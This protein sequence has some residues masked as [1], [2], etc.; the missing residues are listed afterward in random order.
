[1][2]V[3]YTLPNFLESD[4]FVD[5]VFS[6]FENQTLER[7]INL[8]KFRDGSINFELFQKNLDLQLIGVEKEFVAISTS[9]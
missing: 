6:N 3:T 9:L 1:M 7:R 5:I 2:I 4:R 8:P